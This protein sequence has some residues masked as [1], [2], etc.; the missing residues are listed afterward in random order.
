MRR[1]VIAF[2][3]VGAAGFALQ[4]AALAY[5][6]DGAG[7]PYPLATIVAVE[8]A[9]LHNFLWHERWT[10]A[11]RKASQTI[12]ARLVRFHLSNGATSIVGNL[13]M[14][15]VLV[16][17]LRLN[18][19]VANTLSVLFTSTANFLAADRWVFGVPYRPAAHT[20]TP[21]ASRPE[22]RSAASTSAPGVSP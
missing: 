14:T 18:P 2:M 22:R 7:W 20:V 9:V 10:W 13:I 5:L 1:R 19:L 11:D 21:A 12:G 16:E 4:I 3:T 15:V 6:V 17:G 8:L